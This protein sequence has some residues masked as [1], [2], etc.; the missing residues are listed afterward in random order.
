[1]SAAA[2]TSRRF[3]VVH[4]TTYTYEPAVRLSHSLLRLKPR[5][6]ERLHV[7]RSVVSVEPG[8]DTIQDHLDVFG[9]VVTWVS[10][11]RPH[12][13]VSYRSELDI[14]L[15]LPALRTPA[16]TVGDA[17]ASAKGSDDIMVRWMR[18]PSIFVP[19]DV[20]PTAVTQFHPQRP[21]IDTLAEL[22]GEIGDTYTFDPQATTVSTPLREVVERRAG[23][24]QDFAHVLLSILRSQGFAARYVSGYIETSPP[25][26]SPRLV[27]ADA[28][29]AWVSVWSG[30]RWIDIDP[31]NRC[32]VGLGH[33]PVAIGRDYADVA[34]TR[35]VTIGPPHQETLTTSVD[36]VA[37]APSLSAVA[38][39]NS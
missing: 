20:V 11:E 12:L 10:M 27:G 3:S 21:L 28:S 14:T 19:V 32:V 13:G 38:I 36:T 7:H 29:H 24:C 6:F 39:P 1:M 9:N 33:V 4:I 18:L 26:G 23:V 30:E 22:V 34:P 25:P 8:P 2:S 15:T 35:G 37:H 31:T 17:I 5:R 16:L